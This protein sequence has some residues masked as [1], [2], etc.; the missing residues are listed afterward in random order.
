VNRVRTVWFLV[1]DGVDDPDRVSG[2][3]LYDRQVR[4]GLAARGWTMRSVPVA[5]GLAASE[6]ISGIA[7]DGIAL[8]DG[9]VASWAPEA[10]EAATDRIPVVLIAHMISAEFPGA[11]ES[12]VTAEARALRAASAV[13]ATSEWTAREL[14]RRGLADTA[15]ITIAR[16]G[17]REA[18]RLR[19]AD[20]TALLCVG[21]I[22]PHKGQDV[23][24]AALALIVDTTWHCTLVGSQ[25]VD[26]DFSARIAVAAARFGGRVRMPGVLRGS[27]LD[28]AHRRA[29]LLVAPSRSESFGMAVLDARGLGLPILATAVGGIPEASAGGG[30][31]L[32][33][34]EDPRALADALERW[35]GEP[36]LRERLRL[37]ADGGSSTVTRWTETV[38]RLDEVLE[39]A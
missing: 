7:G 4:Q 39:A 38:A 27:A 2:G 28:L 1:P 24:L 10:I 5:D 33:P 15:R 34:S 3:N 26:P 22:A 23:L 31:L 9:L 36:D 14:A 16:P 35:L 30:T 32:V 25:T 11:P 29:G 13:I 6:A 17:T 8:V 21:A 19:G 12:L 20:H 18:T 37:R